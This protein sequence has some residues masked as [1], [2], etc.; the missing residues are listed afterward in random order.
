MFEKAVFKQK[1]SEA[2]FNGFSMWI[3]CD[4]Y[5]IFPKKNTNYFYL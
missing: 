5:L 2:N 3:K 4:K 1:K